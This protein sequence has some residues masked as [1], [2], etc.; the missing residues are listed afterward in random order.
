MSLTSYR[1]APPRANG[2]AITRQTKTPLRDSL[3]S[4]IFNIVNGLLSTATKAWR[5][6]TL[7]LLEQ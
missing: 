3:G 1:T 4:G 5:R 2:D 6:P 7:P